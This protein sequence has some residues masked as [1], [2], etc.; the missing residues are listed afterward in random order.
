MFTPAT[1]G[2]A[3]RP[4]SGCRGVVARERAATYQAGGRQQA[5][6]WEDPQAPSLAD[7]VAKLADARAALAAV[8]VDAEDDRALLDAALELA[9]LDNQVA[10]QQVRVLEAADRREAYRE[11]GA[12][13][14]ASWQ[15]HRSSVDHGTSTRLVQAARRL[16]GLPLLRQAFTEGAV[17]LAH[18][19]A[20]TDAAGPRRAE[21]IADNEEALVGLARH[22]APRDVRRAVRLIAEQVDGDGSGADPLDDDGPDE[23]REL[24]FYPNGIDRLGELRATL[25]PL[26]AELFAAMLE[27]YDR[28]DGPDVPDRLRRTRPQRRHD[29]FQ[30]A[31]QALLGAGAPEAPETTPTHVHVTIDL[32]TLLGTGRWADGDAAA[33]DA[34]APDP[35]HAD[36]RWDGP[37]LK[38]RTPRFRHTGPLSPG[39]ARRLAW[40]AKIT[41]VL[42]MGPWRVTNVGRTQ[43]VLP[44]WL[45]D[46]LTMVHGHC[47]GPDCDRPIA[48]TQPHHQVAWRKG[49]DTDL[50]ATIPLCSGHHPMADGDWRVTYDPDTG[51][52][53]WTGPKGQTINT[54]PPPP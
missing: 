37:R 15:R 30:N 7:A 6:I 16:R 33:G 11:D 39:L 35:A 2:S 4:L 10:A 50:N 49:G 54:H 18:V 41:A 24:R 38:G 23:R 48:W 12:L 13:T 17:T 32:D 3:T 28:P 36:P 5:R 27:A 47:R 42:T 34:E 45:R 14:L 19:W 46:L 43:R 22:G 25:D 53:T 31:L 52:C 40:N 20:V 21:A 9:T 26:A 29:A 44:T 51:T 8:D 1:P